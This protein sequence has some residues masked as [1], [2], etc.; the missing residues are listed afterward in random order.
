MPPVDSWADSTA[1]LHG[2]WGT[3]ANDIYAFGT[4]D[5]R[6]F[7]HYDGTNWSELSGAGGFV[8]AT[9][10]RAM[11]G[12]SSGDVFIA[13]GKANLAGPFDGTVLRGVRP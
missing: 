3:S 10:M 9:Y 12:F 4:Q 11:W 2:I 1:D 13:E 6:T 8:P 7:H 5:S